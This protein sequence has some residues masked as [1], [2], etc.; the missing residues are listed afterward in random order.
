[1]TT[2]PCTIS[3]DHVH[4]DA[5]SWGGLREIHMMYNTMS[6]RGA[7]KLPSGAA[8][9]VLLPWTHDYGSK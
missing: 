8:T 3:V 4:T 2:S 9:D 5:L 6:R 7:M 1:M